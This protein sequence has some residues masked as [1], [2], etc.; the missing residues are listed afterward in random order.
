MSKKQKK[1]SHWSSR[2]HEV[3]L[4]QD[5]LSM[6]L[7]GGAELGQFPL[8]GVLDDG[9]PAE[10]PSREEL[11]L[12]V[13]DTPVPGLTSRDVMAVMKHCRAPVRLTCVTPGELLP[14]RDHV[15]RVDSHKESNGTF[16]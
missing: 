7:R 5:L 6:D 13:N 3:V 2:V 14:E 12:E 11:V 4:A 8:L 16:S 1:R 10:G 9:R 15:Q